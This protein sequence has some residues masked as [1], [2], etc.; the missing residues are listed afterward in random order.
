MSRCLRFR[1]LAVVS[2]A[3][4]LVIGGCAASSTSA[5]E[6][7]GSKS[8]SESTPAATASPGPSANALDAS[9]PNASQKKAALFAY[10]AMVNDWVSAS[11]S[12]NYKDP[13]L[14]QY[15]S[16]DALLTLT[17]LLKSEHDKGAVSK[18]SPVVTGL[19]FGQVVPQNDP[20]EIVIN[21]CLSDEAWLEYKATDGS[22]YNNVPGGKH[23]TQV[24]AKDENGVWKIDQL[25]INVVGTC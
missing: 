6:A 14:G 8:S 18:G 10:E 20:S 16:G 2:G 12:A 5:P 4:A 9:G 1:L 3:T 22:L 11:L 24:L 19:S 7:G 13:V 21:S 25:A 23:R 17:K 15:A